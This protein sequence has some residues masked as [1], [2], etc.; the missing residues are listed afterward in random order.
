MKDDGREVPRGA[1]RDR[2]R[3][4]RRRH[5]G[6]PR[7]QRARHRHAQEAASARARVDLDF[8]PT[9]CGSSFKNKGVQ[10][11][12][13]AV[14]DYLPE[15]DRGQRRSPRSTSRAT[16][17][18]SSPSSIPTSPFRALAFKIMDDRFGALTFTRIYSGT[19]K[20][21][22]TVLNTFTG[23]TERIGRM[24]EMHANDRNDGRHGAGG[25]HRRPRRPEERADRPHPR[26]E[27]NPATLEPMVFPDPGH[28][29]RRR[30]QGQGQRREARQRARQDGR[31]GPVVPRRGRRG[32]RAR[33]SSRAWA[34]CTSTSRST[35]SSRTH[36]VEVDVGKPQVAY[37]ETITKA[38]RR[39]LHPQEA[40]G[41][42]GSVRE[43]RLH[44]SSRGEPGSGFV[45]ESKVVGG[46]V[47]KE[48]IPA[49]EKGF[50]RHDRQGP[51]LRLP[52]ARL[53][54]H[55]HRRRLPRGRLLGRSP[56]RSP[57]RPP[58]ARPCRRP[59]RSS[60]SRS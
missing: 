55:P 38:R 21:G 25:R 52:A 31:R 37:R 19:I 24:V 35:S 27:K 26:D 40:D 45:F 22:D 47:P 13:D 34:S 18:A 6:L 4:G 36:G 3:A 53:Q 41:W 28:L 12:L 44:A 9:Y 32:S 15:P 11:V 57:P 50:K 14:V 16:R 46:N 49:V 1:H 2:R 59:A 30:R 10:H 8:F 60:S 33:R 5:G 58:T 39:Q 23:K 54:G 29:D 42:L 51:A 17:P 20:K 7:G 48:Y 56:S 43:D